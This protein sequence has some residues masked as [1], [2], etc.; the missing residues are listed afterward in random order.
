MNQRLTSL[1]WTLFCLFS[2]LK[3]RL[4]IIGGGLGFNIW[5][6]DFVQLFDVFAK[7]PVRARA[8]TI[9]LVFGLM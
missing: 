4:A 8:C 9:Y 1:A 2:I 7:A 3:A 5:C 6:N